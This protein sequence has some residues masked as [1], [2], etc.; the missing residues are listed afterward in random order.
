MS[1]D[2]LFDYEKTLRSGGAP[3]AE[4]FT[5]A[6]REL[7]TEF[8]RERAD[9]D[10]AVADLR[11]GVDALDRKMGALDTKVTTL[12]TK[13]NALDTKVGTLDT[14]VTALDHK[15]EMTEHRVNARIDLL[16]AKLTSEIRSMG[17]DL[18]KIMNGQIWKTITVLGAMIGIIYAVEKFVF[19][20]T[21]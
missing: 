17:L 12:D 18:M 15:I 6:M 5:K 7:L 16:E 11:Q 10:A 3:K 8:T 4:I 19:R 9:M 21:S 20:M 14:K 1:A 13:V 2:R